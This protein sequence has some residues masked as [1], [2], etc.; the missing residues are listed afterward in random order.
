MVI[1]HTIA[2]R[3][4]SVLRAVRAGKIGRQHAMKFPTQ[5]LKHAGPGIQEEEEGS[6][7]RVHGWTGGAQASD[8]NIPGQF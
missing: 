2:L 8:I 1:E 5:K 4:C 7:V 3:V 6:G